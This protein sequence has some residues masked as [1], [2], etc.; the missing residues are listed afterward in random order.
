MW[1]TIGFLAACFLSIAQAQNLDSKYCKEYERSKVDFLWIHSESVTYCCKDCCFITIDKKCSKDKCLN[2]CPSTKGND[3]NEC[4]ISKVGNQ[5]K[6]VGCNQ[7]TEFCKYVDD[8]DFYAN[9]K[10]FDKYNNGIA[11]DNSLQ[12]R[13]DRC[14]RYVEKDNFCYECIPEKTEDLLN[15]RER[16]SHCNVNSEYCSF[17][18]YSCKD[19]LANGKKC[20]KNNYMC[21]SNICDDATDVCMGCS[22]SKACESDTQECV[23]GI[24]NLKRAFPGTICLKDENCLSDNCTDRICRGN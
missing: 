21:L 3:E 16:T 22:A 20:F 11:C 12:C 10:C 6:H 18:D 1:R 23:N 24:C 13:S 19:K 17:D 15:G 2:T 7:K 14:S 8:K 5:I 9:Y 4:A